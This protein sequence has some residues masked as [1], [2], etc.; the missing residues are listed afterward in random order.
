[1]SVWPPLQQIV[2]H[3]E[4]EKE[5]RVWL[6]QSRCLNTDRC[7]QE[8]RDNGVTKFHGVDGDGL[9]TEITIRKGTA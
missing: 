6:K 9:G 7:V 4:D 2:L 1:M 3:A 8:F 5:L